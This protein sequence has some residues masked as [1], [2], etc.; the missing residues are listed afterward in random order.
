MGK[1]VSGVIRSLA[2]AR[3]K[4]DGILGPFLIY[5]TRKDFGLGLQRWIILGIS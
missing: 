1:K 2:N 3:V 5:G 4:H